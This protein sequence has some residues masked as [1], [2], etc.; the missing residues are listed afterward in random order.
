MTEQVYQ[1]TAEIRAIEARARA[2]RAEA[3]RDGARFLGHELAR[4][5]RGTAAWFHRPK[6]A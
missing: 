2:L 4:L 1:T 5:V 6:A 3:I